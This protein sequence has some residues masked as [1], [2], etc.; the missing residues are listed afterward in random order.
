MTRN[1]LGQFTRSLWSKIVS[2]FKFTVWFVSLLFTKQ[3]AKQILWVVGLGLAVTFVFVQIE[4]SGWD[5][6]IDLTSQLFYH[7][8]QTVTIE[9]PHKYTTNN[10]EHIVAKVQ[11]LESSG[12]VN[13]GCKK[14]GLVN[15]YGYRQNS[16]SFKCY[17]NKTEVKAVVTDWFK[18]KLV[19]EKLS[20]A[21]A[22][23]LYN[24][25]RKVTT[26]DYYKN[27]LKLSS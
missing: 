3:G 7:E 12:G 20:L 18:T 15:G 1:N 26:C 22:L 21:A 6:A 27:Y 23:C 2:T 5:T 17:D 9:V 16:K 13:D 10:L 14:Q 11:I 8:A 4:V 19:D 24:S 25:G